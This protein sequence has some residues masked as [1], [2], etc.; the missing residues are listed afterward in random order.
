LGEL[1]GRKDFATLIRAFARVRKVFPSRLIILGRG[2]HKNRLLQLAKELTVADD[3]ALPGFVGNPFNY[4]AHA[5]L[6][7]FT[8]KWEGLP[9]ALIEALAVGTPVVATDC[10]GGPREV[11]RDGRYGPLVA[12]GDDAG[13][14]EAILTTLDS[15]LPRP[16][17]Q[18]AALPYEIESA[19]SRY[20][21]AL[22]L[23]P[24]RKANPDG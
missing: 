5:A 23:V 16:V 22:N 21:E 13:L 7:A 9:F 8:S 11:L 18:E 2:R 3:V 4:L 19:A 24:A 14:A 17:L 6:F 20:A 1:S 12:I 10:P 15:P